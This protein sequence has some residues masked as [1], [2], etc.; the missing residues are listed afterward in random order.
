MSNL[1]NIAKVDGVTEASTPTRGSVSFQVY[2]VED[3]AEK[4]RVEAYALKKITK[5]LPLHPVPVALKWDHYQI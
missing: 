1:H 3:N 2:G 4:V 5:E